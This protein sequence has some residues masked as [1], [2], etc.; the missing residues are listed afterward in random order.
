MQFG[1]GTFIAVLLP[2][3]GTQQLLLH[4]S[5]FTSTETIRT[6]R[7]GEPRTATSTFT[8]LLT[9]EGGFFFFFMFHFFTSTE[10]IRTIR[11]GEPRTAASN[12]THLLRSDTS[13]SSLLYVHRDYKGRGARDGHLEFHTAPELFFVFILFFFF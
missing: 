6:I 8:Q 7:D 13:S 3:S 11:D 9:S 10:T 2:V 1:A 4:Q 5:W 12:F